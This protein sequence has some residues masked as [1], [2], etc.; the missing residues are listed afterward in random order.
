MVAA[1]AT[2]S[3]TFSGE[4]TALKAT[5]IPLGTSIPIS[6]TGPLPPS[7]GAQQES[8]LSATVPGLLTAEVLH[9][10]TVGQGDRSRSEA[11]LAS[12]S[13]AA[14]G[15]TVAADFL[16]AQAMAV[17]GPG[18]AST[19]G[20][21]EIV[22]LVVDGQPITVTGSPNQ[23]IPLPDNTGKVVINEQSSSPG[24][25][26][27]NAL[28]VVVNG[29]ADVIV[30][31]AHADITCPPPGQVV[32]CTGGDFVTGGGWIEPSGS[33]D[34][35]AVAGGIKNGSSW[36]HLEYHDHSANGPTVHGTGVTKYVAISQT[37]RHIEGTAEVNGQPGY[38]YFVDV[39]D[40]GSPGTN[41][42]FSLKLSNGYSSSAGPSTLGGG[43]IQLH[44]PCQ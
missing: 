13:L 29:V 4:A 6:D 5:V 12:L 38:M 24:S 36:G 14:A 33:R 21:S 7:G 34:S 41:D 20:S 16:M 40:N 32:G 25:I 1:D 30:S 39:I 22:G 9:A 44:K 37:Q 28:H 31:S 23:T 11:S 42:R 17:C 18:G 8:L 43:N 10:S 35:F 26:T 2:S 15:N 3:P 27:V 19:T